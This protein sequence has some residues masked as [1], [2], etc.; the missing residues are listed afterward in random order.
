[1]TRN[2]L[3]LV[4]Q[5]LVNKFLA[6]CILMVEAPPLL[7]KKATARNKPSPSMP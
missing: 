2:N 3:F 1:M 6:V 7:P 5:L 4:P